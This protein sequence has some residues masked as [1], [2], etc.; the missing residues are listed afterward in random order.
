MIFC[1][2][3]SLN[4]LPSQAEWIYVEISY[5]GRKILVGPYKNN[6]DLSLL[7]NNFSLRYSLSAEN[8][9]FN[10]MKTSDLALAGKMMWNRR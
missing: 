9:V 8:I 2:K 10:Y 4:M 3:K 5:L 1:N 6:I 7:R